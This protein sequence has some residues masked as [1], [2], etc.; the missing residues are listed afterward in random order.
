M[1][2]LFTVQGRGQFPLDMLRYDSCYPATQQDVVV[3]ED[4]EVEREVTVERTLDS[5]T[6]AWKPT[7]GRWESYGWKVVMPVGTAPPLVTS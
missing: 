5:W 3:M 1:R 6:K 2:A 7:F 4:R